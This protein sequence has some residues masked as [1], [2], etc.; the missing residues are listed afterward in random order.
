MG[1]SNPGFPIWGPPTERKE[2]SCFGDA[3][4]VYHRLLQ[5]GLS[6]RRAVLSVQCE[7]VSEIAG[8]LAFRPPIGAI[9]PGQLSGSV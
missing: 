4:L 7:P 2:L 6:H 5:I 1:T 3:I 9:L 8:D